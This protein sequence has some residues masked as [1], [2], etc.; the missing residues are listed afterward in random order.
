MQLAAERT[1][2]T[3][4]ADVQSCA[5]GIADIVIKNEIVS[6]ISLFTKVVSICKIKNIWDAAIVMEAVAAHAHRELP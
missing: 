2:G 1:A 3:T 6:E 4:Q 5:C